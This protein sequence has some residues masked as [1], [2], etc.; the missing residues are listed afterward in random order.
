[1]SNMKLQFFTRNT[2]R[3]LITG[4]TRKAHKSTDFSQDKGKINTVG[5]LTALNYI[6]RYYTDNYCTF[7]YPRSLSI[8]IE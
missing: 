3:A 5:L 8:S 2:R 6:I 4:Y 7:S 1:M